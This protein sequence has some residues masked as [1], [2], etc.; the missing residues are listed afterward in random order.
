LLD[1]PV[2]DEVMSEDFISTE[3]PVVCFSKESMT[4]ILTMVG[5]IR[6]V[7]KNKHF[8]SHMLKSLLFRE[9]YF[10]RKGTSML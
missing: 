6:L 5:M 9:D 4:L 8:V 1:E 7:A 2:L 10:T 3:K